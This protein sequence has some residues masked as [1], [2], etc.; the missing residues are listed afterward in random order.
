M[1]IKRAWP[2]IK[3]LAIS[4]GGIISAEE[5]L[6]LA[7]AIGADGSLKK[8]FV[9]HDLLEAVE[10]LSSRQNPGMKILVVG[11]GISEGVCSAALWNR[12]F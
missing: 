1:E 6:R 8:P 7:D 5:Y 2:Q 4:G 9:G 3:I 12:L 10:R 11:D